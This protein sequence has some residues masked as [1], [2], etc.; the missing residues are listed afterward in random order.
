MEEDS[1]Y[2]L[3]IINGEKRDFGECDVEIKNK[4]VEPRVSIRGEIARTYLLLILAEG[5]SQRKPGS[6]SIHGT[7]V[8]L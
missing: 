6:S 8:T 3:V 2:S 5:S 1:N 7:K 4:T